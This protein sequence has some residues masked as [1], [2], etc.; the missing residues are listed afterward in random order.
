MTSRLDF[1]LLNFKTEVS[2]LAS[3]SYTC[4]FLY[5]KVHCCQ[6]FLFPCRALI[7]ILNTTSRKMIMTLALMWRRYD[8]FSSCILAISNLVLLRFRYSLFDQRMTVCV[9]I[10]KCRTDEEDLDQLVIRYGPIVM[11]VT[12]PC[13]AKSDVFFCFLDMAHFENKKPIVFASSALHSLH[14]R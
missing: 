8:Y 12:L 7:E 3:I 5:K 14:W 1:T 6:I 13:L 11:I 9:F 2:T 10:F 4:F